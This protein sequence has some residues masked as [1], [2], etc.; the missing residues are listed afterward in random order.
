MTEFSIADIEK[1]INHWRERRP[2]PD[3]VVLCPEANALAPVYAAMIYKGETTVKASGLEP[4]QLTALQAALP[5]AA[6]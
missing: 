4:D 6:P 1:A 3:G 5:N 2:S